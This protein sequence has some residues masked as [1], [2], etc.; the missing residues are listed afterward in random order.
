MARHVLHGQL[1]TFFWGQAYGGSQEAL[2][3]APVFAIVGSTW[4]ALRIVPMTLSAVTALVLWRVG[5]RT[6]GE[7]A[8]AVAAALYWL[9]PPF[10]IYKL[11]HQWG[12]YASGVLY[13]A[14][15]LLCALRVVEEPSLLRTGLLG[16][17]LGLALWEDQQ[18][19]PVMLPLVA[20]TVWRRRD[21]LRQLWPAL[22]L[23]LLGALPWILWNARHDWTSFVSTIADTTTY[24]HRLRIFA[25]PLLPMLLGLRAPFTQRPLLA[26]A[27]TDALYAALLMLFAYGA[28]RARRRNASL[29]YA[30]AILFPFIY[31]IAPQTLFS[32][33]PRY[34][35]TLSPIIALLL[36][37]LA[38]DYPRALVLFAL[39]GAVSVVQPEADGDVLPDRPGQ[40]ADR[41]PQHPAADPDAR[42]SPRRPC[43]R[44]LLG[45]LPD[46]LRHPRTHHRG[47]K[48]AHTR[49]LHRE[50]D[51]RIAQ[52]RHPLPALRERGSGLP[53]HRLRLLQL[54]GRQAPKA[55]AP[56]Q[57]T[58][59]RARI[60]TPH[61]RQPERL[62]PAACDC[63]LT[64][65]SH[66]GHIRHSPGGG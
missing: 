19:I 30:I 6:I 64:G 37:Q 60:H 26:T 13:C 29:L 53:P 25:S 62:P 5:R 20:W 1:T 15:L 36:A 33:E 47:R 24:Q 38:T 63:R 46:R 57:G 31:A 58:T 8:A 40:P 42:P 12:F 39:A 14:L 4:L 50:P 66:P 43:V 17:V 52:P 9:W 7:P 44:R 49:H 56:R 41:A 27:L 59:R 55:A 28:Y 34:L 11:T 32:Q 21:S 2:L 45:R 18:L 23:A 51:T 16:L 54:A 48:Q 10:E 3:T 65:S 22:P 61:H 35:L